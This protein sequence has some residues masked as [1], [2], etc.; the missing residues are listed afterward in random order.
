[1]QLLWTNEYTWVLCA[2][3]QLVSGFVYPL[4]SFLVLLVV[5]N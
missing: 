3:H 4:L 1:M 2:G 5:I